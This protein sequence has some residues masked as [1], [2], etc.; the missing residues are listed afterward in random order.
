[1]PGTDASGLAGIPTGAEVEVTGVAQ[2]A[3]AADEGPTPP[4]LPSRLTLLVAGGADV[5]VVRRPSW[6][7][8]RR[9]GA[10][11]ATAAMALTIATGW[12]S[13]LRRQVVRQLAVIETQLQAEAAAEERRRIAQEFHDTLEQDLAGI[14][15]RIDAAAHRADDRETR[16]FLEEQ[17]GLLARLRAD[18]HDFL[19][20]LR[21]PTRSQ[22]AL[23]ESAA[24]QAAYLRSLADTPIDFVGDPEVPRVGPA[25][26]FHLLRIMREA[27]TNAVRHAGASRITVRL[28]RKAGGVVMEVSD[29]GLGFDVPSREAVEGHFGVRG[30]RERARRI[31]AAITIDSRPGAGTRLTV[32][33]S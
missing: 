10:T 30:M 29:D 5:I 28:G 3:F 16:A 21:D 23:L 9:L 7:T 24:A 2:I 13:M 20:D 11:L 1:M 4:D 26:Q 6:W 25:V 33:V 18:A 12:V 15:L 14:T 19:W 22:G 32:T 17:H 8:A 27:V 31:G